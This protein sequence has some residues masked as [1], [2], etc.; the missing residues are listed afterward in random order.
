MKKELKQA[1]KAVVVAGRDFIKAGNTIMEAEFGS[2]VRKL[3]SETV[4]KMIGANLV[5]K[6][7]RQA[8]IN[9]L[10]A[11]KSAVLTGLAELTERAAA[12]MPLGIPAATKSAAMKEEMSSEQ[13]WQDAW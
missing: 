5:D 2:E 4:D 6:S 7:K 10:V 12:M 8:A 13:F 3:A 9:K 11:E 1:L